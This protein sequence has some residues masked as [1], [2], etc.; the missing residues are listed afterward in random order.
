[1]QLP[2]Q[3]IPPVP[4]HPLLKG[5]KTQASHDT[6]TINCIFSLTIRFFYWICQSKKEKRMKLHYFYTP[7]RYLKK[8]LLRDKMFENVC[9][10]WVLK[11]IE[12]KKERDFTNDSY[13]SIY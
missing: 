10:D 5:Y 12:A 9:F 13:I 11:N 2:F 8:L 1:M 7:K 3:I 4:F 6:F